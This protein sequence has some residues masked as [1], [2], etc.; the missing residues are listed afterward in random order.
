MQQGAEGGC[1]VDNSIERKATTKINCIK[2]N[3]SAVAIGTAWEETFPPDQSRSIDTNHVY[4][5]ATV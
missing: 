1:V 2:T 5:S 4:A 3:S